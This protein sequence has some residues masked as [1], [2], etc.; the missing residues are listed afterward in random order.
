MKSCLPFFA[1]LCVLLFSEAIAAR[2]VPGEDMKEKH[3]YM[4]ERTKPA[5]TGKS[6]VYD[7]KPS[8]NILFKYRDSNQV[9]AVTGKSF[10]KDFKP[11]ENILF[12]Y[13]D[14]NQ[15]SSSQKPAETEKP[16]VLVSA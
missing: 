5:V 12:K 10:V 13:S 6:F 2:T 3:M 8:E 14:S 15:V 16:N 11:S 1:L 7:F 9:S 4:S